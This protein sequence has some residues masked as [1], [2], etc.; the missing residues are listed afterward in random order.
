MEALL[1]W[2]HKE[3][4]VVP[5]GIFIPWLEMEPCFF[6][7][8]NWII[9]QALTDGMEIRK[10]RPDFVVNVNISATQ[11]DNHGFRQAVVDI[12]KKTKFPPEYLCIELTER[13]KNMDI[14][15]LKNE[16][17]YFRKLGIKIAIDDFGTGNAT[18]NLLTEL[19][20]DELKVDMSFVRG[21]QESKPNQVLVQAVV[22][23]AHQLG[24]KS[25]IE[26]VEDKALFDYLHRYGSTYY[27]GYHFSRPVCLEDFKKLL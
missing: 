25:C 10:F 5:P 2:K 3:F 4:G 20:I 18:L 7:L 21:I 26:G 12:L 1:R 22:S 16:L 14:A 19:P 8:G 9:E 24:Y 17:E 27:Q 15:F 23:C 11:L 13:C 6:E